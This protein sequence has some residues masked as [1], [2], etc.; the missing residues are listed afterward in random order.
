MPEA[1]VEKD[2][3]SLPRKSEIGRARYIAAMKSVPVTF[4]VYDPSKGKLWSS[5][6]TLHGSHDP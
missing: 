2:D 4:V 1:T 3:L 5:V 6:T